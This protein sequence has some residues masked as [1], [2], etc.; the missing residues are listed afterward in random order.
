MLST[1]TSF[2]ISPFWILHSR[3]MKVERHRNKIVELGW[4]RKPALFDSAVHNGKVSKKYADQETFRVDSTHWCN[5]YHVQ[6]Y[7]Q[8]E[9][10]GH[11]IDIG[12]H[13]NCA[14]S[15]LSNRLLCT[16]ATLYQACPVAL[17]L[18]MSFYLLLSRINSAGQH[19]KCMYAGVKCKLHTRFSTENTFLHWVW[20]V[21][22]SN[23]PPIW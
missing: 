19:F 21:F 13:H 15:R 11:S 2:R 6:T 9:Q 3:W 22:Q 7:F 17:S 20:G 18:L 16:V 5:A 1:K 12:A 4:G 8:M 10:L 23:T 14:E